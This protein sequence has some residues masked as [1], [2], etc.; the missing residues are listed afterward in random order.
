VLSHLSPQEI[1]INSGCPGFKR[2]K[3]QL[4]VKAF[5]SPFFIVPIKYIN[6]P[7]RFYSN[8]EMLSIS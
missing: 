3:G 2:F 7:V 1:V 8:K 5:Y 4:E 6:Y